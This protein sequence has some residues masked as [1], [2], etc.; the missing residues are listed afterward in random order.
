MRKKVLLPVMGL[1]LAAAVL[2]LFFACPANLSSFHFLSFS[3]NI[4]DVN[5]S[6][7]LSS[8]TDR[9]FQEKASSSTLNCTIHWPIPKATA[10]P[11]SLCIWG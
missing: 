2:C 3:T 8:L 6:A 5:A 4:D 7:A 9:Y 11:G 10:L 1:A